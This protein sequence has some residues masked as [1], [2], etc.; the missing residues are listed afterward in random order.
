VGGESEEAGGR[1]GVRQGQE[2][3]RE[4]EKENKNKSIRKGPTGGPN[5]WKVLKANFSESSRSKIDVEK[6]TQKHTKKAE[7]NRR[8][9]HVTEKKKK[10]LE[11]KSGLGGTR[12]RERKKRTLGGR[13]QNQ[14]LHEK[15][16]F[17]IRE[18]P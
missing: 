13:N 15:T 14:I 4:K 16:Y 3:L 17:D 7:V 10:N 5:P 11:D 9:G 2:D 1:R 8:S 12:G 6:K 18:K